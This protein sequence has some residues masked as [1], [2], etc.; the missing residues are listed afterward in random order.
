MLLT[1]SQAAKR[2]G[3]SVRTIKSWVS[4]RA[5]PVVRMSLRTVRIREHDLD[6]WVEKRCRYTP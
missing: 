1:Y 4:A 6:R 3:V 2:L 5:F